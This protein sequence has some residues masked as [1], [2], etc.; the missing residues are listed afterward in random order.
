MHGTIGI[1]PGIGGAITL[2][3]EH[4]ALLW[5]HRTPTIA[6][7]KGSK[8]EYDIPQMR[9]LLTCAFTSVDTLVVGIEKVHSLPRDGRVGAFSFGC[10]YGLWLGLLAGIAIPYME[11]PPQRWQA[12]MLAGLPRGPHT[13]TSAVR[14]SKALFPTIPIKAKADWGLADAALIAEYTR[15]KHAGTH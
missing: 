15:R 14:A 1:D 3:D 2:I 12:T 13:K 11:I 10:G 6:P 5:A 7:S 9:D 4:G 8:R